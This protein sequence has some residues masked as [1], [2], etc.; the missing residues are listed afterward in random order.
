[1][2]SISLLI[3]LLYLFVFASC[4]RQKGD[5]HISLIDIENNLNNMKE[6]HLSQF[7]DNVQYVAM[8]SYVDNQLIWSTN[9]YA[10]FSDK[11]I[12]D[13]DGRTCLLYDN[14]GHL[15]R[16]IGKQGRGPGEYTLIINAFLT[17]ENVYIRDY[18]DLIEYKL[19]GTFVKKRKRGFISGEKYR[20]EEAI[21]IN[22]SMIFGN[23]ENETGQDEYKALI[24]DKKGN[25]KSSYKNYILFKLGSGSSH[26]KSPGRA[27]IYK[28]GDRIFF[29]E[30]LNDTLFQMDDN[31]HLL[32][33][34]IFEFGKYKEP[35]SERGMKWDQ[36][37]LSSYINL[38]GVF[39]TE[40]FLILDCG[41]NKFFPA[42]RLTPEIIKL[43][44]LQDYTQWYNTKSVLGIYDKKTR[45]LVFSKPTNTDN[46]L[47][48]SGFYNDIDAGPRFIP[49]KMVNDSTMVMKIKFDYLKEHIASDDFKNSISKYP[50]RKK[51]IEVL[52]DSLN[53]AKFD[54]PVYMFVTFKK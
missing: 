18:A 33:Y 37:D 36:I 34:Y 45:N 47:F 29:K 8:E 6:I 39:E 40:N 31:Y 25:I 35:L 46:H 44:G 9:F 49:D 10:D 53:K 27:N 41:L 28:F 14:Q 48:T 7:A 4:N 38:Y 24:I 15:I 43:P 16:Q 52:V 22:D 32:P 54:N 26:A 21:M 17:N 23:V 13:S 12:V 19:D 1:M 50:E 30:F 3:G 5:I 42:K 20:L 51:R 11:Y 2:K